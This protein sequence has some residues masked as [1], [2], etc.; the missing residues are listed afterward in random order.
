MDPEMKRFWL[1]ETWKCNE[2]CSP[3]PWPFSL[4]SHIGWLSLL[5]APTVPQALLSHCFVFAFIIQWSGTPPGPGIQLVLSKSL[6]TNGK[7]GEERK[8]RR[9]Q[10]KDTLTFPCHLHKIA[11]LQPTPPLAC[12]VFLCRAFPL[13][14]YITHLCV[15]LFIV[16]SLLQKSISSMEI[17]N[18]AS[19]SPLYPQSVNHPF[20]NGR[21]SI[22]YWMSGLISQ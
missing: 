16:T 18:L 7:I 4:P 6:Q 13:W 20:A 14:N 19:G 15:Y 10:G 1:T 9:E 11:S 8:G 17:G 22:N 12:F 3:V 2:K 21:S 5:H